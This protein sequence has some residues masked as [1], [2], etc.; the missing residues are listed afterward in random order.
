[1]PVRH[2]FEQ[3]E[4]ARLALASTP[5]DLASAKTSIDG[6]LDTVA[7]KVDSIETATN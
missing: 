7:V 2:A 5:V 6:A 3:L 1:L 4:A